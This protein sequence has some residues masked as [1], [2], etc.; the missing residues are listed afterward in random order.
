M[1]TPAGFLLPMKTHN[2]FLKPPLT[3]IEQLE[4]LRSRGIIIADE[5]A[6]EQHL[7]FIS[8]YQF[9]GYGIEFE[10]G[11]VNGDK[12]YLPQTTFEQILDFYVFDRKL[13]L[14]VIDAIERI[15]VA[16]RTV[17]STEMALRYGAHWHLESGLFL[18][19][20]RHNELVKAIKKET[21]YL[22]QGNLAKKRECFIQH[23]FNTYTHPELPAVWMVAEVLSLGAWS[24]I[25]SN[26]RS[27]ADQKVICQHFSLDPT[28][29]G[30]W[31][32]SLTYLRNLCAHHSKLWNRVFTLKP[33]IANSYQEVL[34]NNTHFCAQAAILKIFLD[35][36]HQI[37]S[38][39]II[40]MI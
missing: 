3:V 27:R 9:C 29:M 30:S 23:H 21:G 39:Q 6:A 11:L 2:P 33:K 25:F 24:Q 36:I 34:R 15:E 20:F 40:C 26:L 16:I 18:A 14:L 7:R 4:L 19:N 37:V 17:I 31:L 13:R 38:E 28:V 32:H 1:R 10:G 5:R 8:Y 12:S 22:Q 35:V